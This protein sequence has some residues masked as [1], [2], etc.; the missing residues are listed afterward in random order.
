MML[1]LSFLKCI[2]IAFQHVKSNI[3][4]KT[5]KL[6][7]YRCQLNQVEKLS[8]W[9]QRPKSKE[10]VKW[11]KPNLPNPTLLNP[12]KYSLNDSF[13]NEHNIYSIRT[14]GGVFLNLFIN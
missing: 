11:Y 3:Q 2:E 10:F 9:V 6:K 1:R 12:K 14:I 5:K 4:N 7:L 8:C 13:M